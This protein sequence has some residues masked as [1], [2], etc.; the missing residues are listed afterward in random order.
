[1]TMLRKLATG[2]ALSAAL[3]VPLSACSSGG[4]KE[5][6][7]AAKPTPSPS[8]KPA[9]L[10][11][12]AVA[13]TAGVNVKLTLGDATDKISGV[14]DATKKVAALDGESDGETMHLVST[15]G[16]LYLG[17]LKDLQG[18]TLHLVIAKIPADHD[19]IVATDPMFGLALL[20]GAV[21]VES[22]SANFFQGTLDLNKVTVATQGGRKMLE[23]AIRSGG[24]KAGAVQ[25]N[26]KVDAQG[27]VSEFNVTLPGV[28][29]GS[30]LAYNGTLS[31][32]GAPVTA[33]VPT[34]KVTE[35]PDAI[36]QK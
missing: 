5:S 7:A 26:A 17:G 28:D 33:E 18:H 1:M 16:D 21:T 14:Y 13:K 30:D 2:V 4:D 23:S 29:S 35:A 25:F 15:D 20:T 10:L 19:L 34:T 22:P 8:P 32:F 27:Y 12:A 36:Y 24:A 11:A 31:D 3:L 6:P 9:E